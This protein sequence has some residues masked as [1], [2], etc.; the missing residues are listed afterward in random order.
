LSESLS[1]LP[2]RTFCAEPLYIAELLPVGRAPVK[3]GA[4][5]PQECGAIRNRS[6]GSGSQSTLDRVAGGK[7]IARK[8]RFDQF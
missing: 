2:V 3:G 1:W 4:A 5:V 8:K 6:L 7:T